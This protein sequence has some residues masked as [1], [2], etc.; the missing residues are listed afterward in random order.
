VSIAAVLSLISH[1]G[2]VL[3]MQ[4]WSKKEHAVVSSNRL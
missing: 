1:V 3:P 4:H 2:I